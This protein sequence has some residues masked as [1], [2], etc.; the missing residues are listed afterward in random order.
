MPELYIWLFE[1]CY[2]ELRSAMKGPVCSSRRRIICRGIPTIIYTVTGRYIDS[3]VLPDE[4]PI[5]SERSQPRECAS[6]NQM[7]YLTVSMGSQV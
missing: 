2:T 6:L 3:D 1:G 5:E 7:N 4:A